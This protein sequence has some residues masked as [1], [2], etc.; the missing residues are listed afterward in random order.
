MNYLENQR[1]KAC[2][3]VNEIFD[4][5]AGGIYRGKE[6]DFVLLNPLENLYSGIRHEAIE[7]FNDNKIVWWP[8]CNVPT[9]HLLSSQIACVNH[10][11]FLRNNKEAALKVLQGLNPEFME[12]CADFED[13]YVG[14]EVTSNESYLNEVK[15]GKKQ[16]RGAN[17]TSVDA[18]MSGKLTSGKKIQVLIEW[19]YTESYPKS[20]KADGSSGETRQNRYNA[21]IND[22]DSPVKAKVP[23]QNFYYEPIYQL[24]RQTLLA[25]QMVKHK[26]QELNADDWLHID[27]IPEDNIQ[28]RNKVG[29]PD[30]VIDNLHESWTSLL[31]KPEKYRMFTPEDLLKPLAGNKELESQINY[32]R[33]RYW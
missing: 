15:P 29:A 21:L 8:G 27:V 33:T 24:M 18:M 13:G 32:L 31:K 9:G 26:E 5:E 12:A 30:L 3:L 7:Y 4:C 2:Q 14:F 16:T 10:L 19:K 17:C 6:R 22:H 23:I 20:C 28:L 1:K 11:C 25:W